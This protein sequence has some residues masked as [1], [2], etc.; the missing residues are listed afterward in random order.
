MMKSKPLT[1]IITIRWIVLSIL[2]LMS[3]I[4]SNW[5]HL[6]LPLSSIIVVLSVWSSINLLSFAVLRDKRVTT[7]MIMGQLAIDISFFTAFLYCS[8]GATNPFTSVYMLWVIMGSMLL[9]GIPALSLFLLSVVG[10]ICL[11]FDHHPMVMLSMHHGGIVH[12]VGMLISFILGAGITMGFVMRMA[13]LIKEQ[14]KLVVE[15]KSNADMGLLSAAAAH[16][17]STPLSSIAMMIDELKH[18]YSVSVVD[19][20]SKEVKRAHLKLREILALLGTDRYEG[21]DRRSGKTHFQTLAMSMDNIILIDNQL[22]SDW[23][24]VPS[25][26]VD[27]V[28]QNIIQNALNAAD[29]TVSIVFEKTTASLVVS[30]YD[31]GP[32]LPENIAE[33]LKKEPHKLN[34]VGV[35]LFI[36]VRLL[37]R[38]KG[39]LSFSLKHNQTCAKLRIPLEGFNG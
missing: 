17:L 34:E 35:G 1:L 39:T 15:E 26:T 31:D 19:A 9:P 36:S 5:L 37:E 13:R 11:L 22:P 20:C 7:P 30:I 2:C 29:K 3:L 16:E 23:M 38:M 27:K 10:Y 21:Q 12:V 6:M 28:I 14:E 4:G 32:G 25:I 18:D 24:I 8:G 33:L